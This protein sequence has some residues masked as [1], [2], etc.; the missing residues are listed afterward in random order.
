MQTFRVWFAATLYFLLV[1]FAGMEVAH[2]EY[3][4][5][6]SR[7][8]AAQ[9]HY[10][11]MGAACA[12]GEMQR[13]IQIDRLADQ[14]L[15][16]SAGFKYRYFIGRLGDFDGFGYLCRGVIERKDGGLPWVT[17]EPV[18]TQV[19]DNGSFPACNVP[20]YADP[21]TGQC[22]PPKCTSDCCG[23]CPNGTNP[24]HTASGNKYQ[25][26]SD[27]NGT[28]QLPMQFTRYYNSSRVLDN[29]S[30]PVGVGWTH[31]YLRRIFG[32][33]SATE[34]ST[35]PIDRATVFR[36]DGR[37][38]K[39]TR[40][41][42]TWQS[43]ADV[44]ERLA[45][46]TESDPLGGP[47]A[48]NVVSWTFTTNDDE[49]ESYDPEGR[50][51]S[52]T[53]RD[54]FVQTLT[55]VDTSNHPTD[56]V[57][58]VADP[59][60]RVL[61]FGY[62]AGGALTSI[63]DGNSK[64][65]TYGYTSGN[66]TSATYPE[67]VGTKTR[68]YHYNDTGGPNLPNMLTG[69]TDELSQ[70]FASW[71]YTAAGRANFSVHG[72]FSTG[73]IDK[74]SLLFNGDGTTTVT[75]G[76]NQQR[77][78]GFRV[79]YVVARVNA[80]DQPCDYCAGSAKSKTFDSNG[81]PA[82]AR[83]FR[84]TETLYTYN[85]RG[86]ETQRIEAN[87]IP[88]PNGPPNRITPPEKRTINAVW[89]TGFR[90]PNQRTVVN[91]GGTIEARTDWAFNSR[92]QPTARCVYD[93]TVGGTS[94]YVCIA[95]GTPVPGIRRWVYTY[96]DVVNGTDCPLVGLMK[97]VDGPRTDV[98]DT[99]TYTYRIADDPATPKKYRKGDLWKITNA[100]SQVTEYQERDG[101]GRPTKIADANGVITQM[102]YHP[103]GWL[104]TRTVKGVSGGADA[105]TI[106]TYDDAGNVTRVTQ[107]EPVGAYLVYTYDI[108]HRLTR[109]SDS[110]G[111][112]ID[113]CP[114]GTG[115]A[116]C[117]DALGNR[118]VENTYAVGNGTPTRFLTRTFNTLNRLT[119]QYDAQNRDTQF[120]YDLNGNRTDQ[121][122]PIVPTAVKMHSVYDPLNRL[123]AT[124]QDYQGT[125]ASTANATT[126]YAY[127]TRDNL[128]QVTDPN[129][130]PT[131]YTNDG[132]NNLDILNSPDTSTN[133]TNI[134]YLQDAAGN[135][136][137]QT[138]ARSAVTNYTYD[139]LN[140]LT[141]ATYPSDSAL[142]ISYVYDEP[143]TTTHCQ[144][145]YPIGRLTTMTDE[146]GSTV[147]CYDH[148]G[149]VLQ[150]SV[151]IAN[152][153]YTPAYEYTVAD[154]LSA[155]NYP[156][157]ARVEYTRDSLGRITMVKVR[158]TLGGTLTTVV[159]TV[160]YRPFGPAATYT[161]A[162]GAQSLA[163]TYDQNYWLTD[164]GG[165]VLN[166]HF[167]RDGVANITRL[168]TATPACTGTAM[169]QYVYDALY[170]LKQVQDGSGSLVEGY[171][172]NLTGD[173]LSK[174]ADGTTTPYGYPN[175]FTSHHLLT[176]GSDSRD[177][178]NAGN[179]MH[180]ST[181][182][183]N[184]TFDASNRLV[185]YTTTGLPGITANYDYNGRG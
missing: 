161:F 73:T 23:V 60:G 3:H 182:S 171:A 25:V 132:L 36:P 166:L 48:V 175:P 110:L 11:T 82:S 10:R 94:S 151:M 167:C 56:S 159:S 168:Q 169:E 4:W 1:Q 107:P 7:L 79:Q 129:N 100:L 103:R 13:R 183:R 89:N 140:R 42:A 179:Q 37:M 137:R 19:Y 12:I 118:Q 128:T 155:I 40:S 22:G 75:D 90:V 35:P 142:N 143:N 148:R 138:D 27:F 5:L 97:S 158:P 39:F 141:A 29:T 50:L 93:L 31:T 76:K 126:L 185:A 84:E 83:D 109:I 117:L 54:G 17:R 65:I 63:T 68:I 152:F 41:G 105:T 131:N 174:T 53:S 147:Y 102:T 51:V 46:L 57:Q 113:Y 111:N 124:V 127:D 44:S 47:G 104:E 172:Y 156:D 81:Y 114:G 184:L 92:G 70:R 123:R 72:P 146:S 58:Q 116:T 108:A 119:D 125:D 59:Q 112:Y 52:I 71:G 78:F 80:L 15:S 170:R 9:P 135:R 33:P 8:D 96:C 28:G 6:D 120:S 154:R 86:L 87:T 177:Y 43:D 145:S 149:N 85:T 14:G 30:V 122:D 181:N 74:T 162:A 95:T 180:G 101:N 55:Y 91:N 20:G 38:L 62:N 115:T 163:L 173:R 88:D 150:K 130:L 64:T 160:T 67:D 24:I 134:T 21:D 178:D 98:T 106:I 99:M 121:T 2:A 49:V 133:T 66:L 136:T 176:V 144:V 164:V 77:V 32:Y 139:A 45:W 69:I 165:S 153:K 157:G 34:T 16:G 26:E 18:D 61:N